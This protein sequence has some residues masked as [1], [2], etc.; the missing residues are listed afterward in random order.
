[1]ILSTIKD[2]LDLDSTMS[3]Y[4]SN[5]IKAGQEELSTYTG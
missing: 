2:I 5:T 4:Y 3:S 1:M